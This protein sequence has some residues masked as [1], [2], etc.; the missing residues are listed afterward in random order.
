MS[1]K[2]LAASY[3]ARAAERVRSATPV[4]ARSIIPGSTAMYDVAS[5]TA[6]VSAFAFSARA[7][8][9]AATASM[10]GEIRDRSAFLSV[11][12]PGPADGSGTG[13]GIRTSG[14]TAI[15]GHTP[16]PFSSV[17]T[18]SASSTG[19]YPSSLTWMVSSRIAPG[20]RP[21]Y[22]V[23]VRAMDVGLVDLHDLVDAR[24]V[25]RLV[26]EEVRRHPDPH[27]LQ[28]EGRADDLAAQAEHVRVGVRAGEPGAERAL[29]VCG[30]HPPHP[31]ADHRAA[32]ADTVDEDRPV[33]VAVRHRAGGRKDEVGQIRRVGAVRAEVGELVAVQ[34]GLD[35]FLQRIAGVVAGQRDPHFSGPGWRPPRRPPWPHRGR[36][37]PRPA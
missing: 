10:A 16:I 26:G 23:S 4:I 19:P 27:D 37:T 6:R 24:L 5:S 7:R 20:A 30:E 22:G 36:G 35:L 8:S 15:P 14:P 3:T 34:D 33:H 9:S 1:R 31:V 29:A 18:T 21:V 32:V 17:T 25:L 11:T 12:C 13:S 2:V 28:C